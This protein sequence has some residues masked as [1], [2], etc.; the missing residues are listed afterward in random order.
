MS[1]DKFCLDC[2][3]EEPGRSFTTNEIDGK[4]RS[5]GH[6][7]VLADNAVAALVACVDALADHDPQNPA[8]RVFEAH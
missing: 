1:A 3:R 8:L 2:I 6:S 4:Q 5:Y 7:V